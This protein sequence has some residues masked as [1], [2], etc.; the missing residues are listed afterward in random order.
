M[1]SI[2]GFEFKIV[3]QGWRAQSALLFNSADNFSS[4]NYKLES[5][6]PSIGLDPENVGQFLYLGSILTSSAS[7]ENDIDNW[8]KA[9]PT[10]YRELFNRTFGNP[11]LTQTTKLRVYQVV[12][13]TTLLY[14]CESWVLY[15][16]TSTNLK[17]LKLCRILQNMWQEQITNNEVLLHTKMK[18]LEII[19]T[20][21]WHLPTQTNF[22]RRALIWQETTW[23]PTA[24]I[25]GPAQKHLAENR[26]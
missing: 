26:N 7:A 16:K 17:Q 11:G 1:T 25:Q 18:S 24:S 14:F 6:S 3:L 9:A 5:K 19:M 21:H 4:S 22:L 20:C 15:W 10:A 2:T 13:I 23:S 12:V 8:I